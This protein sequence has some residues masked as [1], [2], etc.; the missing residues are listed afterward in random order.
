MGSGPEVVRSTERLL[1]TLAKVPAAVAVLRGRDLTYEY[2]NDLYRQLVP[3]MR[4]G[5]PFGH[6]T[7]QGAKFRALALRAFTSGETI[8]A[9]E[10]A[11]EHI[12]KESRTGWFD[13]ILQPTRTS[14]GE[15]DGVLI[16]GAEVT[17]LVEARRLLEAEM[18]HGRSTEQQLQAILANAPLVLFALDQDGRFTL[19]AGR[20]LDAAG[21]KASD[22]I[23]QSFWE[24][25]RDYPALLAQGRR[26]LAGE[27]FVAQVR[28]HD[29]VYEV[30]YC[31][32]RGGHGEVTCVIGVALN[33]T[34]RV[35]AEEERERLQSRMLQAQKLESLGVL[36]GGIAHDFN[37]LLTIISGN[38]AL[39]LTRI[40]EDHTAHPLLD[41]VV[42]A[43]QRAADLTRQ[44][45]AYSGR[46]RFEIRP[47]DLATHVREIAD[48]LKASVPK[49]VE[50]RLE[51][52]ASLPTVQG[53]SAQLHQVLMNLVI[54]GAEAIGDNPGAVVV[55]LAVE[56]VGE[57]GAGDLVGQEGLPPGNYLRISVSDT[58][59]G[60]DAA[61]RARIFDP[62]FTTKS[63][64]RGLGLAAVLGIVRGHHGA[65]RIATAP[66]KGTTFEVL[67]PAAGARAAATATAD[68]SPAPE[69]GTI[70]VIDDE[71]FVRTATCRTLASLGYDVLEAE[72]GQAGIEL[73]RSRGG[74]IDAIVLDLTMPRMSGEETLRELRRLDPDVPV[75]VFSG[76]AEQD[77]AERLGQLAAGILHKPFTRE[78]LAAALRA[79][80]DAVPE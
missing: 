40:G 19:A 12:A 10:V 52:D 21:R 2:A 4:E 50:L 27:T 55:G 22:L 16:L 31:P 73:F 68:P 29:Q 44:M 41:D 80:I 24:R 71:R 26:A 78:Q 59:P 49:K 51:L 14:A 35:Q 58:G 77:V 67:L 57:A 62:F 43:A 53:D 56:K 75:V 72:D 38:A 11:I 7:E 25:Y 15:V 30:H 36:A 1:T 76:Y 48:L 8:T 17:R 54:N 18:A 61:T 63:T 28:R 37:N 64:G 34:A 65:V 70:L 69:G 46:G 79:A 39:A 74:K 3:A 9:S 60:M 45:L 32:L 6:L 42:K 13:L 33:A 20:E 66:G 5:E 23:G 47:I